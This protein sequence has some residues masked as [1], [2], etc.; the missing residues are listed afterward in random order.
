MNSPFKCPFIVDFPSPSR[1][2]LADF[3]KSILAMHLGRWDVQ[4]KGNVKIGWENH[5]KTIGKP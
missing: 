3:S 5:R 1:V 4:K 2:T